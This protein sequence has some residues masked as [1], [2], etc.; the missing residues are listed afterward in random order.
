MIV[1]NTLLTL[2]PTIYQ[3]TSEEEGPNVTELLQELQEVRKDAS[4][5]KEELTIY[6][7]RAE[8]L[9]DDLQARDLSISKLKEELQEV[10]KALVKATDSPS[11]SPSPSPQ[12]QSSSSSSSTSQPKRKGG[13]Q[14][15]GKG[16][17][18]KDKL[19][20]SRKNSAAASL[21]SDKPRSPSLN[22]DSEQQHV[23]LIHSCTQTEALQTPGL[24]GKS[25]SA[26]T[27]EEMEEVIGDFQEKIVQMQELHAAEILDME[28]RHISESETLRRD[29]QM[30]ENECKALKAVI[31]KLRSTE[32]RLASS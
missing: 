1:V 8:K 18:T 4:T 31:D 16:G 11:P 7:Q 23:A 19:S 14:L 15:T 28:A 17:S 6:R 26:A 10:R 20:L 25:S 3:V 32:V 2:C 12:P 21:S 13:K 27:K 9:Q 30:L 29:T 22:S 5:A 24:D